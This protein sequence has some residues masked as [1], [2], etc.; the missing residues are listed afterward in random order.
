MFSEQRNK[1][2]LIFR[3][4]II[5]CTYINI[6]NPHYLFVCKYLAVFSAM[7]NYLCKN[8]VQQNTTVGHTHIVQLFHGIYIA[9]HHIT[10][11]SSI[12]CTQRLLIGWGLSR[13]KIVDSHK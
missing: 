6:N 2:V 4:A 12:H 5:F 10:Y 11:R 13:C 8:S 1:D 7:R 9:H 3:D